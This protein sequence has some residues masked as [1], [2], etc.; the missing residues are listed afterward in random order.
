MTTESPKEN[1]FIKRLNEIIDANL[2]NE[3]FGVAELAAELGMSR[4]TLHRRIKSVIN[5]S[6][7]EFIRET[8]LKKAYQLLASETGTV[9]EI[10]YQVGFSSVPYFSRCFHKFYGCTP[11]DVQKGMI[12]DSVTKDR[13]TWKA[14]DKK[15]L[16]TVS[17]LILILLPLI[18][19]LVQ[20]NKKTT[21]KNIAVLPVEMDSTSLQMESK[22]QLFPQEISDRLNSV[23]NITVVPF[24]T[25]GNYNFTNKSN[26]Q[27][28]KELMV[29][30]IL[31]GNATR[32]GNIV[33]IY[34]TL[35]ETSTDQTYWSDNIKISEDESNSGDYFEIPENFA[36]DAVNSLPIDINEI[37]KNELAKPITKNVTALN[38]YNTAKAILKKFDIDNNDVVKAKKLL[39]N[40]VILDTTFSE[41]Y[42]KIGTIYHGSLRFTPNIY[43]AENYL[44]SA[45]LFFEKAL[46]FNN[47]NK[48]AINGLFSYYKEK[49]FDVKAKEYESRMSHKTIKNFLF[50]LNESYK[51]AEQRNHYHQLNSFY[52]YM[53]LKP[54]DHEAPLW[55]YHN[56]YETLNEMGFPVQARTYAAKWHII[57]SSNPMPDNSFR[58]LMINEF[59]GNYET[60]FQLA[61]QTLDTCS[62]TLYDENLYMAR[63]FE[64]KRNFTEACKYLDVMENVMGPWGENWLD[65]LSNK[66]R[67]NYPF[68]Y[69][70]LKTGQEEKA[71]H[72]FN[73]FIKKYSDEIELRAYF[74]RNY[75][76]YME[77][78]MVHSAMGNKD[79]AFKNLYELK[80]MNASPLWFI[81]ELKDSPWFDNI[82]EN[83]EF[84][85]LIIFLEKGYQKEHER[86]KELLISE[87]MEPA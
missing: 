37:E 22:I 84:D 6:V 80:K 24:F 78:A 2:H 33:K 41:A 86:I 60:A 5:K 15:Y 44:D 87:G 56:V 47:D 81:L 18:T 70:Y 67:L 34:F 69:C 16:F 30:F 66:S 10:A 83:P 40:A 42:S 39:E 63:Y 71:K 21:Q 7:S 53:L 14:I 74:A 9:S 73:R 11:G 38:Y 59:N 35:I 64:R 20:N 75:Y 50:Y 29:D 25:T 17:V 3:H 4:T 57:K 43:L 82:R 51:Y 76:S 58:D 55:V 26:Q 77:I 46:I 1:Q 79:E 48:E 49:G 28:G 54:D 52:R 23:Q 45:K 85:N 19:L 32:A 27:I 36:L 68:G 13:K 72:Y 12:F 62:W 65:M 8:R 61:K 31:R